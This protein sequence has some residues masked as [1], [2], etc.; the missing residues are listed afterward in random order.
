MSAK[1][2]TAKSLHGREWVGYPALAA[3]RIDPIRALRYGS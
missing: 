1:P 3:T 2:T